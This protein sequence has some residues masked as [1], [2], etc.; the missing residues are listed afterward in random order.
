MDARCPSIIVPSRLV[1]RQSLW[2]GT[3]EFISASLDSRCNWASLAGLREVSGW[4]A[5]S[6]GYGSAFLLTASRAKPHSAQ[7]RGGKEQGIDYVKHAAV[8]G[9]RV[10]ESL[11]PAPRLISDSTRSPSWAAILMAAESRMVGHNGRSHQGE[12]AVLP[13]DQMC[14]QQRRA[15]GQGVAVE[16]HPT[17]TLAII[18]ASAPSQVLG[19]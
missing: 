8:T 7:Q 1:F 6:A 14:I 19:D 18:E 17:P 11:I 4:S 5:L 10:P 3:N 15:D 12:Q 16:Q 9:S 2:P 13:F